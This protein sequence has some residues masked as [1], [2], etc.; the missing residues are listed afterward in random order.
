MRTKGDGRGRGNWTNQSKGTN[1]QLESKW[2]L[3][4]QYIAR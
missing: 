4:M 1:F 3:G 2:V